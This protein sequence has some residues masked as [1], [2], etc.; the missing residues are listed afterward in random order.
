MA[1][2][3]MQTSL[4][5]SLGHGEDREFDLSVTYRFIPG[6]PATRDEPGADHDADI[7]SVRLVA[8]GS[9]ASLPV[10][11]WMDALL[12]NDEI[13]RTCLAMDGRE[14]EAAAREDAQSH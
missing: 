12:R 6:Y 7:L 8:P 5:V 3:T 9:D 10:P 2:H 11:E 14:R 1:E 13:L 4:T